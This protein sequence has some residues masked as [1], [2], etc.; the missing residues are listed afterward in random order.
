MKKNIDEL[1]KQGIERIKEGGY[2]VLQE[3]LD[4]CARGNIFSLPYENQVLVYQQN[5]DATYLHSFQSWLKKGRVPKKGTAIYLLQNEQNNIPW[6]FDYK[7]TEEMEGKTQAIIPKIELQDLDILFGMARQYIDEDV[8]IKD[9]VTI[10][11]QTYVRAIFKIEYDADI[12]EKQRYLIQELSNYIILKSMSVPS[13][14]PEPLKDLYESLTEEELVRTLDC[15]QLVSSRYIGIVY[16]ETL[17]R[18]ALEEKGGQDHGER[19][20]EERING[21]RNGEHDERGNY[22]DAGLRG[23]RDAGD[24]GRNQS[25]SFTFGKTGSGFHRG[26]I[27]ETRSDAQTD[28]QTETDRRA[29]TGRSERNDVET[30]EGV[31]GAASQ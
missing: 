27:S 11:T 22:A 3:Y 16:R 29:E 2:P 31:R 26:E 12:S 5:K 20:G 15:V 13:T 1:Y 23:N 24:S 17:K 10:L 19:N 30:S 25:N 14:L 18:I 28:R 21:G 4:M 9:C 6:C 7:N 8:N